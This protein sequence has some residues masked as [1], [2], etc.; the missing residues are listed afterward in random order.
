[1][2]TTNPTCLSQDFFS[3]PAQVLAKRLLGCVLVRQIGSLELR[4]RIVE[5]EAYVGVRDAGCHSYGGKRTARNESMYAMPGRAYVY[6][7]YGVHHCMNVVAGTKGDPHEPV[8]VLLRALEPLHDEGSRELSQLSVNRG[9][10]RARDLMNGPGKLC[11]AFQI[12]RA[13]DG[14]DLCLGK[15]LWIEP[16]ARARGLRRGKRIGLGTQD[17]RWRDAPLR[18]GLPSSC[19]SKPFS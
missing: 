5:T 19:L 6:F 16:G 1:M 14:H 8:A 13:L 18:F 15:T 7:T 3:Q 2:S 12:D 9:V 17:L 10:E 4:G 11:Q